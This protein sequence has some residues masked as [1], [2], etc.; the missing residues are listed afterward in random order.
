MGA[1]VCVAACAGRRQLVGAEE[2][3]AGAAGIETRVDMEDA[4]ALFGQLGLRPAVASSSSLEGR[5]V[6]YTAH[7]IPLAVDGN[8]T[9]IV[10]L[11]A[12]IEEFI[13]LKAVLATC[14]N[15]WLHII[16]L[17]EEASEFNMAF[18]VE[19]CVAEDQDTP[20]ALA[21]ARKFQC[22]KD[23][24]RTSAVITCPDKDTARRLVP[25]T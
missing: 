4:V 5:P 16:E 1:D 25:G 11:V 22:R 24:C 9:A 7:M 14:C 17:P 20:L 10:F 6:T 21:L 3:E 13:V 12:D 8:D 2:A 19:V 15:V 18:V 23:S